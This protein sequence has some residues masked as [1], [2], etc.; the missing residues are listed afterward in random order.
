MTQVATTQNLPNDMDKTD[1]AFNG[2]EYKTERRGESYFV[3]TRARGEHLTM[4][5]RLCS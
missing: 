1:L 4:R 2:R 5:G 3:R